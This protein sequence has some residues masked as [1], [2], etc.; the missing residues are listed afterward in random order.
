M[1]YDKQFQ[2]N[3]N[4][5]FVAFSYSEIQQTTREGFLLADK[6]KLQGITDWLLALDQDVLQTYKQG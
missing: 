6:K 3:V 5:L 2:I 4:F 1:Y